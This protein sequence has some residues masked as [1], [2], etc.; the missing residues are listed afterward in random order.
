M[1]DKEHGSRF[2]TPGRIIAT[3]VVAVLVATLGYS[4]LSGA[5]DVHTESGIALPGTPA[6]SGVDV[7]PDYEIP[8]IDGRKVKMSDYR[9]KVLVV[10]F[11]ATWCP[12][13]RKETPHLARLEETYRD[14]GL[15][16]L[17]L[18]IDDQGRSAPEDIRHF[19]QQYGVNYTVGMASGEMFT[20]YLGEENPA[21]P[22]TLVFGRDG[23]QVVHL[24]SYTEFQA[25]AL[26]AAVNRALAAN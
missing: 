14:R 21:I 5:F 13:C 2:W 1:P 23:K 7:L 12:P 9:G 17:G 11:W 18:H 10:D 8:T 19:V 4:V 3:A 24:I 6:A 15:V 26:D 22:Q 25:R 16:V 20:E